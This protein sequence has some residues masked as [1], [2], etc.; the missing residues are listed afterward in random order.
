MNSEQILDGKGSVVREQ[1]YLTTLYS[2][3]K[4]RSVSTE[5]LRQNRDGDATAHNPALATWLLGINTPMLYA[6]RSGVISVMM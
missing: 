3:G 4:S 5:A 6:T 1:D 2:V